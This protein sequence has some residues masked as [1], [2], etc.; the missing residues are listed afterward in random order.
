MME[1]PNGLPKQVVV[2]S[3]PIARSNIF[4]RFHTFTLLLLVLLE[5]G[6]E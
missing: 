4:N 3:N 5:S 2:G 1:I 6:V